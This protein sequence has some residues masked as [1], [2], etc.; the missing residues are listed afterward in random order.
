MLSQ[1]L[2]VTI[3]TTD[4]TDKYRLN[5]DLILCVNSPMGERQL[6][7]ILLK[8]QCKTAFICVRLEFSGTIVYTTIEIN[9]M[10]HL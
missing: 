2:D 9:P 10:V 1:V 7:Y 8:D 3:E 6:L 4:F 5:D